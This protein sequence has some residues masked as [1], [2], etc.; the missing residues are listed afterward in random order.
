MGLSD[1]A[2]SCTNLLS[3][4]PTLMLSRPQDDSPRVLQIYTYIYG[5]N[6]YRA[7]IRLDVTALPR[8]TRAILVTLCCSDRVP[9]LSAYTD[10]PTHQPKRL[11]EFSSLQDIEAESST[12]R[13]PTRPGTAHYVPTEVNLSR[14]RGSP[15]RTSES[16]LTNT[17]L[18]SRFRLGRY[19]KVATCGP[20]R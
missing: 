10:I 20:S 12:F 11:V 15:C 8:L 13:L 5:L 6:P 1:K 17:T 14:L 4:P 3:S 2:F 19:S 9:W 16:V 7:H 18:P